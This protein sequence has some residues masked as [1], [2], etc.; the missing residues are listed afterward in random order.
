MSVAPAA[1]KLPRV[2]IIWPP[3]GPLHADVRYALT[4]QEGVAPFG[5]RYKARN[6][7]R[8]NG[9][10]AVSCPVRSRGII[11]KEEAMRRSQFALATLFLRPPSRR[12]LPDLH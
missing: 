4:G 12:L 3:R 11:Y 10:I 7:R 2:S 8:A 5:R 1:V 6:Y 9:G